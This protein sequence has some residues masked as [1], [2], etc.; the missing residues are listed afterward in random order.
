M[1]QVAQAPEPYSVVHGWPELP[2]LATGQISGVAVDSHDH[3][4]VFSRREN[5]VLAMPSEQWQSEKDVPERP[6][7]SAPV[8]VFEGKTGRLVASWGENRF[9]LPH[10]LAIDRADNVWITDIAL[11]Q[12]FEFS[13]DGRLLLTLGSRKV[14]GQDTAHFNGP[15]GVAFAPDGSVYISDGYGN[16]RVLEFSPQGK[17]LLQWGKKGTAAG[18]FNVVHA[19]AVDQQGLVYVADRDNARIQVFDDSG[20]FLREWT[21]RQLG[22]PWGV[23]VGPDNLIYIVYGG[24]ADAKN[25]AGPEAIVKTDRSGKILD[26][27]SRYGNYDGQIIWGHDI[28][29]GRDGSVY[30]GDVF[31]GMRIQ[32]FV[33]R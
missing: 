19:I 15:S 30:V 27:W 23:A 25:P 28:A 2:P 13:H 29:V 12:V 26:R 11:H 16:S 21:H 6:I 5:S 18:E 1:G 17:Y 31:H 20:H 14:S 8:L 4:F 33:P 32:K 24:N 7:L 9:L 3:V 22:K 10:G